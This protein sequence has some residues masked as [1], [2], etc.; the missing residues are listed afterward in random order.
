MTTVCKIAVYIHRFVIFRTE[1]V[2]YDLGW[3][4]LD[5]DSDCSAADTVTEAV[6]DNVNVVVEH[7]VY[8]LVFKTLLGLEQD[9]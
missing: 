8:G 7:D 5:R 1:S 4:G 9:I 3:E 2:E 6:E